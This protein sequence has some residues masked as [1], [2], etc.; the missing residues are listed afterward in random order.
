MIRIVK[1]NQFGRQIYYVEKLNLI[2]TKNF[3]LNTYILLYINCYL[4]Y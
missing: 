4:M 3:H 1:V 2:Q